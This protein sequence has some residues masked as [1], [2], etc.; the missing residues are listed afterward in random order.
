MPGARNA[1]EYWRL[2]CDGVDAVTEDPRIDAP[3]VE[4]GR[5]PTFCGTSP[6]LVPAAH[7]VEQEVG[8]AAVAGDV[9]H[10]STVNA[11]EQRQSIAK[12]IDLLKVRQE[13]QAASPPAYG[14]GAASGAPGGAPAPPSGAPNEKAG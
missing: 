1:D 11:A 2:L 8:G 7:D 3:V 12:V 10:Y 4:R 13:R 9:D 6:R 5:R 14:S